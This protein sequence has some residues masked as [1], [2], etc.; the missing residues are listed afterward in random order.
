MNQRCLLEI[1]VES[2]EAALAAERG[3]ADRIELCADLFV[4]GVTPGAALLRTVRA[5]VRIPIFSMVRPRA[6]DFVYSNTEFMEMKHFIGD[7]KEF[8]MDGIV[9]GVLTKDHQV[10]VERTR[11]LVELAMPLPVTY[12]RAF[13]DVADLRQALEDVIQTGARRILT[14][15]GTKSA[16]AGAAVLAELVAAAGDRIT[17]VPGAGINASTI[18]QVVK[19]TGA[20]EFHS[21]LGSTLPYGSSD[22]EK[23]E[24]EVQKL[25]ERLAT[26]S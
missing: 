17:I 22:Y 26:F 2:L 25:A 1:S 14:S 21:G 3:V 20:R 9:L 6:G 23:F 4:G 18:S 11:E 12:H 5:Q 10:D 8:G 13:D 15:G 7:A 16:L 24:T 19:Q